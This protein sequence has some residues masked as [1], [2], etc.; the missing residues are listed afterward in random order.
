MVFHDIGDIGLEDVPEPRID[1]SRI[2]TNIEPM[3]D[4]IEAFKAFDR[5]D[6]GRIKVVLR[7]Q[8]I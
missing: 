2:L 5:H 8:Q 4:A 1:P 3:S 6:K 7:P